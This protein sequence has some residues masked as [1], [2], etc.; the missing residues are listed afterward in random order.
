[1][2]T[3]KLYKFVLTTILVVWI[4]NVIVLRVLRKKPK[5]PFP[6]C[7]HLS[8]EPIMLSYVWYKLACHLR[9]YKVKVTNNLSNNYVSNY[10]IIKFKIVYS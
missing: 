8:C 5:D 4:N 7:V 9:K 2:Y 10:F 1:M 3:T 6:D